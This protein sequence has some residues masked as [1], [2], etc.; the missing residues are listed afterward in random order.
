MRGAPRQR[1]PRPARMGHSIREEQL[2]GQLRAVCLS[3]DARAHAEPDTTADPPADDTADGRPHLAPYCEPHRP[4]VHRGDAHLRPGDHRVRGPPERA[5]RVRLP[6]GAHPHPRGVDS[7]RCNGCP[8][9]CTDHPA[10]RQ[11]HCG[12]DTAPV[13]HPAPRLRRAHLVLPPRLQWHLLVQLPCWVHAFQ[14]HRLPMRSM[15]RPNVGANQADPRA[16]DGAN[17]A[18]V[19]H[20]KPRLRPVDH[21]L[22]RARPGGLRVHLPRGLRHRSPELSAL[23]RCTP[24]HRSSHHRSAGHPRRGGGRCGRQRQWGFRPPPR[25]RRSR[26]P[27][28][29]D[30]DR[31]PP[32]KERQ[33]GGDHSGGRQG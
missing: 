13:W 25:R 29:C 12:P 4:P 8:D 5:V 20:P 33:D 23:C 10:H 9:G 32:P 18:P 16:H 22:W 28:G 6:A 24:H 15:A 11:S 27:L 2:R 21:R 31:C 3:G 26:R 17:A 14:R 1:A 7:L 19:P 30:A